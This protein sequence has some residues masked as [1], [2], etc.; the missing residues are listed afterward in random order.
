MS[1]SQT[2]FVEIVVSF[3]LLTHYNYFNYDHIY[4]RTTRLI[5]L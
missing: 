1:L 3:A 2:D 4:H 5:H